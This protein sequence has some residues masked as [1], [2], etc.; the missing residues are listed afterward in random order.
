VVSENARFTTVD[1]LSGSAARIA[2]DSDP[3][4]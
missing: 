3:R 2:M 4:P 1:K